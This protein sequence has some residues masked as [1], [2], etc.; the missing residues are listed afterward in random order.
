MSPW[1]PSRRL[2]D[3]EWRFDRCP[4]SEAGVCWLYE[5]FRELVLRFPEQMRRFCGRI[6]DTREVLTRATEEATYRACREELKDM[7]FGG[8]VWVA[9]EEWPK[10]PY[11]SIDP[12]ERQR[13][14]AKVLPEFFLT[15]KLY[16]VENLLPFRIPSDFQA[17][18]QKLRA[19]GKLPITWTDAISLFDHQAARRKGVRHLEELASENL[20]AL[21]PIL[22]DPPYGKK[23]FLEQCEALWD[24][25][26]PKDMEF[27]K[28]K[29]GLGS[30]FSQAPGNLR[31]LAA[32]RL[33]EVGKKNPADAIVFMENLV[34]ANELEK[35]FYNN[36]RS[37]LRAVEKIETMLKEY[38]TRLV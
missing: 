12:V 26:V 3:Q 22:V 14:L 4:K 24:T 31:K 9:F 33:H 35:P 10:Q 27:N 5:F 23:L 19:T 37:F 16:L 2:I 1:Q 28:Q 11:L 30:L 36:Q 15:N 7:V 8:L 6:K 20:R 29:P 18:L 17:A 25:V 34:R 13:R 21:V 32:Y 38:L